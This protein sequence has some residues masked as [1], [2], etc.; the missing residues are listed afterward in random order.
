MQDA[1]Y[2]LNKY[3]KNWKTIRGAICSDHWLEP[4]QAYLQKQSFIVQVICIIEVN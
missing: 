4:N 2:S 3:N 1:R